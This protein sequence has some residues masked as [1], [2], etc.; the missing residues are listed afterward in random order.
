MTKKFVPTSNHHQTYMYRHVCKVSHM[1]GRITCSDAHIT[2]TILSSPLF[3]VYTHGR[4][5][6]TLPG[7]DLPRGDLLPTLQTQIIFRYY[8]G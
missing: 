2:C 7:T 1:H 3:T 4:V 8:I 5:I 6:V